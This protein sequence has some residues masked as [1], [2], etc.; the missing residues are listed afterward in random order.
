[1]SKPPV[2]FQSSANYFLA[3]S[4]AFCPPLL[5]SALESHLCVVVALLH[6]M[7]IQISYFRYCI[8][9]RKAKPYQ[10]QQHQ[11]QSNGTQSR[12]RDHR[13]TSERRIAGGNEKGQSNNSLRRIIC[14]ILRNYSC[15]HSQLRLGSAWC[16]GRTESLA[17]CARITEM[18]F[19]APRGTVHGW[20]GLFQ[21][22]REPGLFSFFLFLLVSPPAS[23]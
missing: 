14:G 20:S 7:N 10:Q 9:R 18:K 1:M 11:H 3:R 6:R 21:F 5:I 13:E 4:L 15:T 2:S 17:R 22:A 23:V 19:H 8:R 16:S 12:T